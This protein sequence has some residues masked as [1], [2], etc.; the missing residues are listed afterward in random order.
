ML[1][2]APKKRLMKEDYYDKD[3]PFVDDTELA[4][5]EQAAASKDGFFVYSG[6]LVPDGEKAVV[7]R[8]V[9]PPSCGRWMLTTTSRADGTT[10]RGRGKG[11]GGG[12]RGPRGAA[13]TS[14][15]APAV[16]KPRVTKAARVLMEQEKAARENMAI[17]AAKPVG[18]PG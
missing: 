12:T 9:G 8:Y 16:R 15:A 14:K 17:L 6:P 3:D 5:E 18:Y 4:W 7:E 13:V 10:K 11:R 2:K 1:K